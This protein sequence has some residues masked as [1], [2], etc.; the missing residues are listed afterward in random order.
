MRDLRGQGGMEH[1]TKYIENLNLYLNARKIKQ[2][3]LS[4]KTG[5]E[6]GKIAEILNGAQDIT[7]TEME[8]ISAALG[9]R[10]EYFLQD[11]FPTPQMYEQEPEKI[12]FY[13][14]GSAQK[15]NKMANTLLE[16]LENIDEVMSAKE[17][18]LNISK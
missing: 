9:K 3:Y 14:R 10:I 12:M 15:Q 6:V 13:T 1:M 18:F 2:T 7:E 11:P 8:K 16:F 17:R 4:M 5:I